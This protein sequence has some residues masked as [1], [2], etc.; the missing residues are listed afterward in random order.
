MS[1][2]QSPECRE[3]LNAALNLAS[4]G[5]AVFPLKYRCKEPEAR[6]RGFYDAGANKAVIKRWFG[7]NYRRNLGART[8]KASG[9]WVLDVDN[10]DALKLL[11]DQHGPL[12]VTRQSQSS[13]GQHYWFRAP[14]IP[15][16]SSASRVAPGIDVKGEGGYVV[17]APSVHPDGPRYRWLNGEPIAEAP[18]WLL[19]L[20]RKPAPPQSS[21]PSPTS[22]PRKP[23]G[24]QGAYGA[25]ALRSECDAIAA[26]P[27]GNRNNRL[28]CGSFSLHQLVAGGELNG[29]EVEAALV[30]ASITN[31]L[32]ADDGIRSVL[33]TIASG[34]RAGL[35]HPRGRP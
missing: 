20:A 27:H 19:V 13:R 26:T 10:P 18:S 34:R 8:G 17:V 14:L 31:G 5:I 30:E 29:P 23:S 7:G 35:L 21:P 28:N 24:R 15:V 12:P 1:E 2:F 32:V 33:A 11:A 6:S 22:S 3:V 4:Q 25:A 9:V 16:Q